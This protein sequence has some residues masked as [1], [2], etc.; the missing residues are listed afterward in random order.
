MQPLHEQT[1]GLGAQVPPQQLQRPHLWSGS[2]GRSPHRRTRPTWLRGVGSRQHWGPGQSRDRA[3]LPHRGRST[4]CQVKTAPMPKIP[5]QAH[6]R[7]T[8][9]ALLQPSPLLLPTARLDSPFSA[10]R[11]RGL[12]AA[13]TR[14]H[15]GQRSVRVLAQAIALALTFAGF[16]CPGCTPESDQSMVARRS[17]L[18][19][20]GQIKKNLEKQPLR[21][22]RSSLLLAAEKVQLLHSSYIYNI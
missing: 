9:G 22:R 2:L 19:W 8:P 6:P 15:V 21:V 14:I 7:W 1:V 13:G 12:L 18:W 3:Q 4:G 20:G 17:E 11:P 5:K 10:H 16:A